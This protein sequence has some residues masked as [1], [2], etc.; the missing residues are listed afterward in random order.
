MNDTT[1]QLIRD[2]VMRRVAVALLQTRELSPADRLR[3][4][5][6]VERN[7]RPAAG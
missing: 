4:L 3:A 7:V 5:A 6:A 1:R 2:E